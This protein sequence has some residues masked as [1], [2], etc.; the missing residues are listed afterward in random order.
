MSLLEISFLRLCLLGVGL[1]TAQGA[2]AQQ[3]EEEFFDLGITEYE[4]SCMP[5]HGVDGHGDGPLAPLLET[6][7]ADL[8]QIAKANGDVFPADQVAKIIDGRSMLFDHGPR[9]MPIWGYRYR[10]PVP[11][12]DGYWN[13]EKVAL[14]RIEALVEY[15]ESL[16][17]L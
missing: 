15:L 8:T 3:D 7:P 5:C 6:T 16:Q 2:A 12:T 14:S 13:T 9:E 1:L 17:D 11:E 4:L 10:M